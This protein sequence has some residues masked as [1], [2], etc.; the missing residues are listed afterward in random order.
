VVAKAVPAGGHFPERLGFAGNLA[1]MTSPDAL[2]L[3]P[4]ELAAI[5][6]SIGEVPY[7]WDVA[8]DALA[9]G[10]NAAAVLKVAAAT[11]TT[12][13]AY[14]AL[15]DPA[16]AT[17][18]FDAVMQATGADDGTGVAYEA[19][20]ALRA[21]NGTALWVEDVGRWFAGADGRPAR[22][23]GVVRVVNER[24]AREERLAHLAQFDSL[25]GEMNRAQLIETLR[26]AIEEAIR[27]RASCGLLVVAI[28]RLERVNDAYGFEV[29]DAVIAELA[30]RLRAR[31]RGGDSLG[32]L[33]GNKFG[34]VLR[35][36]TPDDLTAAAERLLD[37]A[38]EDVIETAAGPVAVTVTIGGIVAPRHARSA[39][40]MLERAHEALATAKA[41][42]RGSFEAYRPSVERDML[43]RESIRATDEIVAALNER[44]IVVAYEPVVETRSRRTAFYE[45]LMRIRRTDGRL[46]PASAVIPIAE[47]LG[48]V[49]LIDCRVLQLVL[50]DLAAAPHLNASVNLSPETAGDPDWWAVLNAQVRAHPDIAGRLTLEI[51]ETAAVHHI[52]D[53][54]G[55]VTRAKDLGCRIA[56]DDFG[57][58]FTSFRN[59]RRLQ[60]DIVKIDGSFVQ[61]LR[62]SADDRA[63][64]RSL[65]E[66]GRALGLKTV[67]EWVQDE[68]A[69]ALLAEWGCDYLQ[70]E[71]VG[72]ASTERPWM[73]AASAHA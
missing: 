8:T 41:K 63:F 72:T 21:D 32:R 64:V 15:L 73:E 52:G 69:A 5:L 62:R 47:R 43:R 25:T 33:S 31:M 65:I 56:I 27:F 57:A 70:G 53:A 58:G 3:A 19:T 71:L 4:T 1:Q 10:D 48:L 11:I 44:R 45:A 14:A 59:L 20:Y 22:A 66:L 28:D 54:S 13:R 67:A 6:R 42:R 2:D 23:H 35:N 68:E 50:A 37:A 30:K 49:R 24:H 26:T 60:V 55:F 46:I 9:W 7:V 40:E 18:R 34:V 38:R 51:T 29:A 16:N 12:G 36:C 39:D 61:N 17:T